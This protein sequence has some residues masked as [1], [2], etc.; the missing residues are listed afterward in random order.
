MV[1]RLTFPQLIVPYL[2]PLNLARRLIVASYD[3]ASI[4]DGYKSSEILKYIVLT[5]L[6]G[7]VIFATTYSI[8]GSIEGRDDYMWCFFAYLNGILV[9]RILFYE[10]KDSLIPA[11]KDEFP[12]ILIVSYLMAIIMLGSQA[13]LT[14]LSRE[15]QSENDLAEAR[16]RLLKE[17][18][19]FVRMF[20]CVLC[21]TM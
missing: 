4:L 17:T 5:I 8:Y 3:F 11:I 7:S 13:N 9:T 21:F 16:T 10:I 19:E 14:A 20:T 18:Y 2:N 1:R 12:I 6:S 15:P